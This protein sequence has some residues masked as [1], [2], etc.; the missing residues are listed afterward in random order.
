MRLPLIAPLALLFAS[1]GASAQEASVAGADRSAGGGR[2]GTVTPGVNGGRGL[3][4][5]P[6]TGLRTSGRR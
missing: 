1:A 4:R 5:L 3:R 6:R 2:I